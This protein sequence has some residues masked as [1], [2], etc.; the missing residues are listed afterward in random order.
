MSST[1]VKRD[2]QRAA[3]DR[4]RRDPGLLVDLLLGG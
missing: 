3:G 2:G 1:V 4:V